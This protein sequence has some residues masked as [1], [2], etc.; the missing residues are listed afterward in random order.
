VAQ[1]AN[2]TDLVFLPYPRS[3]ERTPGEAGC[4]LD[5]TTRILIRPD[6]S[7]DTRFAAGTVRDAIRE[8]AGIDVPVTGLIAAAGDRPIRLVLDA[9]GGAGEGYTLVTG[10][11]GVT[12]TAPT[13]AGLFYGCQTLIQLI[14]Q[15]GRVLPAVRI[16]DAPALPNRG[17]MLDISRN[18]VP[19]PATLEKL[20]RRLAHFKYNQLQLYME[21]T[22]AGREH[23][24]IAPDAGGLTPNDLLRLD[25]LCRQ[26]HIDL[27]PNWQS[28]GHQR[29]MLENPRYASLAET[30]W[31]WSFAST[32]DEA[33][34]VVDEIHG[35]LLESFSSS[36]FNIDADEP[37][38]MGLGVSKARTDE[39]GAGRV[40]IEHIRRLHELVTARGRTMMMWADVF[41]HYPELV[42]EVPEDIVL[43]DWWYEPKARYD[44][45]EKL[46]GRRFYVCPGSGAWLSLFPRVERAIANIEGFVRAGVDAGAEGMLMTDWGDYG[47]FGMFENGWYLY[48]WAAECGWGG[49]STPVDDYD[50][51][52]SR[53]FFRDVSGR[54]VEAIR[55]LGGA[56]APYDP[57]DPDAAS[58]ANTV[59]GAMYWGDPLDIRARQVMPPAQ[60]VAIRAAAE[61]VFPLLDQVRDP[62]IRYEL[63]LSAYELVVLADRYDTQLAL[64]EALAAGSVE[65]LD[66]GIDRLEAQRRQIPALAEEFLQ[67]WEG[68]ARHS[69]VGVTMGR[70]ARQADQYR[71]AID[72]VRAQRDAAAGGGGVEGLEAYDPGGFLGFL[73]EV[74]AWVSRLA[75][76]VGLESLPPDI[77][78]YIEHA[79]AQRGA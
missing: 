66:A 26:H 23:P 10:P 78:Q 13:E 17:L 12:V 2:P 48:L 64:V 75:D 43:L 55:A 46:K 42:V 77:R 63:G 25:A 60:M 29:V 44:S 41:W 39:I 71:H 36:F 32:S 67:R 58:E 11:D 76:I 9:S 68:H 56:I 1:T 61:A 37:W 65:A 14:Q 35:D 51:A 73:D 54:Q 15:A 8:V 57:G 30:E 52:V 33:F 31:R 27:V 69:E 62:A 4:A 74:G 45:V 47:H 34:R 21:H 16:E 3:V 22:F 24:S 28:L 59:T 5:L 50:V 53:L 72:W 40:Y 20:V 38:D 6:A 7:A 79:R 49:A 70:F 18:K 19:T